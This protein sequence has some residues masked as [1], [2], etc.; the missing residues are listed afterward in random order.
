MTRGIK[1]KTL[2]SKNK[3]VDIKNIFNNIRQ[4]GGAK[5]HNSEDNSEPDEQ[6]QE[7]DD[8]SDDYD[9][10]PK[11]DRDDKDDKDDKDDNDNLND[12]DVVSDEDS[13]NDEEENDKEYSEDEATGKKESDDYI[14]NEETL[15]NKCYSK[16]AS[17]D[18]DIDLDEIFGDEPVSTIKNIRLSKPILTK[19]ERVRLMS[20]RTKQLAQGAKPML[21]NTEG[22]SSKEIALLELKHKVIPLIIERPVPNSGVERWKLSE[23]EILDYEF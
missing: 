3:N 11:D 10:E 18:E 20:D 13:I 23:L 8:V 4:S 22:L 15:K 21:K 1:S 5:K 2:F 9:S 14:N 6:D 16:Y 19:Y 17:V 7:D 12:D